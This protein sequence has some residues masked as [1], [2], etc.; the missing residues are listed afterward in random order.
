MQIQT[1]SLGLGESVCIADIGRV[2]LSSTRGRV[3]LFLQRENDDTLCLSEGEEVALKVLKKTPFSAELEIRIPD[4]YQIHT[5][6]N[7]SDG[8]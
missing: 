3:T 6:E 4:Y 1:V 7:P 5:K 8:R 2:T